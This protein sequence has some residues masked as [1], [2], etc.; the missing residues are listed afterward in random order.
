MT[1]GSNETLRNIHRRNT[2]VAVQYED[3]LG[4]LVSLGSPRRY[5]NFLDT[6]KVPVFLAMVCFSVTVTE[7]LP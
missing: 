2:D 1:E 5:T 6:E 3:P 4:K 7:H